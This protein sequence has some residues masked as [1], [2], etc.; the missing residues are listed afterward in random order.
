MEKTAAGSRIYAD[1][2]PAYDTT[3]VTKIKEAGGIV[4]GKT[5]TP[6]FASGDYSPTGNPWNLAYT[7]G[8]S[9]TS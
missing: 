9:S 8:G 2:V 3:A 7:P 4:L 6:E 1:F 5:V